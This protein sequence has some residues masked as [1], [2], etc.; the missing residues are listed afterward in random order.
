MRAG[1]GAARRSGPFVLAARIM[2]AAKRMAAP[3]RD[4]GPGLG[5]AALLL[6]TLAAYYP[7]WQG[8]MVWDDESHVTA[9][10]LRPVEGLGR[11]WFELGATAQYYPLVHSAF[12]V[13]HRL[14]GDATLGYHLVNILL[15]VISSCLLWVILRR[16]DVPGSALAAVAFALHPVHVESVAWITELKN[17]LSG[18]FFLASALAY[19]R[20]DRERA[21]RAYAAAAALFGLALLS[22]SVTATLPG[23][24]LVALWWKRGR[25]DG[26]RDVVPL[27]PFVAVGAAAGLFTAWVE[28]TYM[29]ARGADFHLT[30]VERA[31]SPG[32]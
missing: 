14:W 32:G 19:L 10:A 13:E 3:S 15:H 6:A 8:G 7:A 28:R 31:S 25:L 29:G 1:R 22:K 27:L 11:I 5:V 24:L 4:R 17:T 30:I 9:V 12:W 26:R 21:G 20:F 18:V 23:V 2:T 16:L